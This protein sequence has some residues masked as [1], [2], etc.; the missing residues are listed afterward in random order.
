MT[1]LI[2]NDLG[3][4]DGNEIPDDFSFD[5]PCNQS[6]SNNGV[7]PCCGGY[8]WTNGGNYDDD[9]MQERCDTCEWQGSVEYD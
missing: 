3:H 5:D 8:T 7:C 6:H 9:P 2:P 4:F 1:D